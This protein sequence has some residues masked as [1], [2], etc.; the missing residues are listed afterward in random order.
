VSSEGQA[1]HWNGR[2]W[3][4]REVPANTVWGSGPNDVWFAG[5]YGAVY[6]F[7]GSTWRTFGGG[8]GRAGVFDVFFRGR[9]TDMWSVDGSAWFVGDAVQ[10]PGTV[11]RRSPEG[12]FT[13]MVAAARD[14]RGV[15]ASSA[16]EAWAVGAAGLIVRWNGSTWWPVESG[17]RE[18]LVAVWGSSATNV[19]AVGTAGTILHWQGRAWVSVPSG[20]TQDLLAVWGLGP[21]DV[22]AVGA[23]GTI[24]HWPD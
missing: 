11:V 17:T 9:I 6:Q 3:T 14:L 23:G 22:W 12:S 18:N 16:D 15:W 5:G 1:L 8:G 7:D 10:Q 4:S 2:N 19:W 24:L 20:S 21:N 13:S